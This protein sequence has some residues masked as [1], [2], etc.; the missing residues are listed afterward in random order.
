[1][2]TVCPT[3]MLVQCEDVVSGCFN[4]DPV[5]SSLTSHQPKLLVIKKEEK[6]FLAASCQQARK[7]RTLK[8]DTISVQLTPS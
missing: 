8:D 1:V 5:L 4:I 7:T 2:T 6:G 3:V